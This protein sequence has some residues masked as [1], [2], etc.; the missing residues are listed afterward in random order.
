MKS[1]IVWLST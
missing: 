1:C